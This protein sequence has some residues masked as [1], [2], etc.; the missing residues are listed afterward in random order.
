MNHHGPMAKRD[1]VKRRPGLNTVLVPLLRFVC[2]TGNDH[3]PVA[4]GNPAWASGEIA[5]LRGL[6]GRRRGLVHEVFSNVIAVFARMFL[7]LV[8]SELL[9]LLLVSLFGCFVS[10]ISHSLGE[11]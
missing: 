3:R 11:G 8:C 2:I 6:Q 9:L 4:H 5:G 7:R 1:P 10:I